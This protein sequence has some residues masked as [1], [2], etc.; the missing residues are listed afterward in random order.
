MA[1]AFGA[2]SAALASNPWMELCCLSAGVGP[3]FAVFIQMAIILLS[4]FRFRATMVIL[5]ADFSIQVMADS[6]ARSALSPAL[7]FGWGTGVTATDRQVAEN[8]PPRR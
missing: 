8:R 7:G 1:A 3:S 6:D 5:Q 4:H 2:E